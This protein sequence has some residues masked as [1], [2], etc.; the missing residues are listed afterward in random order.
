MDN[1]VG[2]ISAKTEE[3][4]VEVISKYKACDVVVGGKIFI[5][6]E[7]AKVILRN[8]IIVPITEQKAK[9]M[10]DN[11]RGVGFLTIEAERLDMLYH[12]LDLL[13][14]F[15]TAVLNTPANS[16]THLKDITSKYI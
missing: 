1:L 13:R 2:K 16:D 3:K 6:A 11:P 14:A 7:D 10:H 9:E 5:S 15:A 8:T 12:S 4:L